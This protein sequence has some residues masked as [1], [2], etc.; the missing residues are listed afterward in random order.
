[1]QVAQNTLLGQMVS[2]AA[3]R[4]RGLH[5]GEASVTIW[6]K[7]EMEISANAAGSAP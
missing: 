7:W 2:K 6:D 4:S 1:M 5:V 3:I